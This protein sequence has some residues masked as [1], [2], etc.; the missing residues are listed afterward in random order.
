LNYFKEIGILD[1]EKEKPEVYSWIHEPHKLFKLG[2]KIKINKIEN[3]K[4]NERGIPIPFLYGNQR[5]T[6][7]EKLRKATKTSQLI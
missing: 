5:Y 1:K 7:I 4:K 3:D 2:E 6:I